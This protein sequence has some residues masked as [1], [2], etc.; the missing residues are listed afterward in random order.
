MYGIFDHQNFG[1]KKPLA[2]VAKHSVEDVLVIVDP[3]TQ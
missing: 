2:L 1:A 3:I